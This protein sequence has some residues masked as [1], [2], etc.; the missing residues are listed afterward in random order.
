MKT[1]R[2]G[3][4]EAGLFDREPACRRR[5]GG[6]R[7]SGCRADASSSGT[8]GD[9]ARWAP[10]PGWGAD[11]VR[12]RRRSRAA[13]AMVRTKAPEEGLRQPRRGQARIAGR[14]DARQRLAGTDA[15][16][17]ERRPRDPRSRRRRPGGQAA[18]FRRRRADGGPARLGSSVSDRS[19]WGNGGPYS[20]NAS[21]LSEKD[22]RGVEEPCA[23]PLGNWNSFARRGV[24]RPDLVVGVERIR[25]RRTKHMPRRNGAYF[26]CVRRMSLSRVKSVTPGSSARSGA[27]GRACP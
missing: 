6:G 20:T 1:G 16:A 7:G 22:E 10:C 13:I 8:R 23:A 3:G 26:G 5:A 2:R 21:S 9:R 27:R 24:R 25:R 14:K 4:A 15:H 12:W 19:S 18:V 17:D 11:P